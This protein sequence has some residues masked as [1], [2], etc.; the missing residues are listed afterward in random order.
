MLSR[1]LTD[2]S[3]CLL[4]KCSVAL[5]LSSSL[6]T[7]TLTLSNKPLCFGRPV[8]LSGLLADVT[9]ELIDAAAQDTSFD[10]S[11]FQAGKHPFHSLF[12]CLHL[13]AENRTLLFQIGDMPAEFCKPGLTDAQSLGEAAL[14]DAVALQLAVLACS[15]ELLL[16]SVL[17]DRRMPCEHLQHACPLAKCNKRWRLTSCLNIYW[18]IQ[19]DQDTR[20]SRTHLLGNCASRLPHWGLPA[21]LNSPALLIGLQKALQLHSKARELTKFDILSRLLHVVVE[22]YQNQTCHRISHFGITQQRFQPW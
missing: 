7:S 16:R 22:Q 5:H 1:Q 14:S 6:T 17:A 12:G 19:A 4:L 11:M 10:A 13:A 2:G 18:P 3:L 8:L 21:A 15:I 20:G 9:A